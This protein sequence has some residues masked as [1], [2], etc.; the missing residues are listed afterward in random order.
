MY[1]DKHKKILLIFLSLISIMILISPVVIAK[2]YLPDEINMVVG[3]E[4]SIDFNIPVKATIKAQ[5]ENLILDDNINNVLEGIKNINLND[6]LVVKAADEGSA[7]LK[8]NLLGSIPIKTVIVSVRPHMEVIPGGDVIGIEIHSVGVC[9]V[10]TGEFESDGN[11]VHPCKGKI[12]K[13]DRILS[14]NNNPVNTKEDFKKYI[15]TN[16]NTPVVLDIMRE[17]KYIQ[18]EVVPEYSNAEDSYK[19]GIWI[20][21]TVQGLGTLTYVEPE[22]G[23]FG[24]LGH[25]ITDTDFEKIIP[26][27][28]GKIMEAEIDGIKKGEAGVPGEISG[29]IDTADAASLGSVANNTNCGIFG[30]MDEN[31]IEQVTKETV[32]VATSSEV[33]EGE[34]VIL[35]DLTGEGVRSYD[36][37]IQKIAKHI[38]EPSKGMIVKI[39]DEELLNI[40]KGIIQGMSGSPIIQNDKIIGAISHVFVNDPTTGYGIFIENM[41][42]TAEN[43]E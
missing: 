33:E 22:T 6:P 1:E 17:D 10:G 35:A 3:Q 7:K 27:S 36:V 16:S 19:L 28:H 42:K 8:I 2:Y 32:Q 13:G 30:I 18:T 9:V 39:I 37:K 29:I 40:T 21:D 34:A 20:K 14:I 26:I 23:N 5:D 11:Q 15:E 43:I 4:Y 24:A 41:L 31:D 25:G 38:S 12:K